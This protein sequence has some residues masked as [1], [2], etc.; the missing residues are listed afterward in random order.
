MKKFLFIGL[1]V[2]AL[3]SVVSLTGCKSEQQK[4]ADAINSVVDNLV[5]NIKGK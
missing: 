5:D 3:V 4:K 1:A 2:A